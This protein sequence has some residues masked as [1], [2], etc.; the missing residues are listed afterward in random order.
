M[1]QQMAGFLAEPVQNPRARARLSQ[2]CQDAGLRAWA[3]RDNQSIR[4]LRYFPHAMAATTIVVVAMKRVCMPVA[5]FWRVF[6]CCDVCASVATYGL[7]SSDGM[8]IREWAMAKA[9][10]RKELGR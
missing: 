7:L 1:V 4:A 9:W 10:L 2:Q 8:G 5:P 3:V 6:T